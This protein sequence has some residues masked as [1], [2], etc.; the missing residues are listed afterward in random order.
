MYQKWKNEQY[1]NIYN[2]LSIKAKYS[3]YIYVL[4]NYNM[5]LSK[6]NRYNVDFF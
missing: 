3:L 4:F 1:S 6:I 5:A 2:E